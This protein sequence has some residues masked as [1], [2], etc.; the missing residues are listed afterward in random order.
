MK[1]IALALLCAASF[2]TRCEPSE[3]WKATLRR[4]DKQAGHTLVI[5]TTIVSIGFAAATATTTIAAVAPVVA[6]VGIVAVHGAR[7]N[8]NKKLAEQ[9]KLLAIEMARHASA[10]VNIPLA[11]S[12]TEVTKKGAVELP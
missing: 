11:E 6:G 2:A 8:H 1:R 10:A 9:Q 4:I 3:N 12:P 7:M 5:G